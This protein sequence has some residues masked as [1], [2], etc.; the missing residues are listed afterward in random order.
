MLCQFAN[1]LRGVAL[2]LS[3]AIINKSTKRDQMTDQFQ[4]QMIIETLEDMLIVLKDA[5]PP[6]ASGYTTETSYPYAVG[7]TTAGID[8]AI[9]SL[10][11]LKK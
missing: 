4:I 10:C 9:F 1:W 3:H 6:L 2:L 11:Q 5:R 8:N 7:Y